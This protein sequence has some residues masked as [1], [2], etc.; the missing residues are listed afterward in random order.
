MN[1]V[2]KQFASLSKAGIVVLIMTVFLSA[3]RRDNKDTVIPVISCD[4]I[5]ND[6]VWA[7]RG[8]SID[9]IVNCVITVNAK[10]TIA[11]GVVIQFKNNAGIII[12]SAGT[13]VAAGTAAKPIVLKGDVDIAGVWKGLY[14]KS[15]NVL[16][17]LN[18]CTVTNAGSGSFDGSSAKVANIRLIIESK[19][20]LQNSTISKSGK[21]GLLVDGFDTDERNPLTLFAANTFSGNMNYPVSAIGAVANSL[22]GTGSSYTGNTYDKVQLRGGR[23][24]GSHTWTKLNVPYLV[25]AIVSAGYYNDNGSLT[26]QPGATIQFTG[27][28]GLCT[29]DY[30][31]TSWMSI[32]GTSAE[33]ITLTGE[34]AAPGAWKGIAFQSNS[35]NNRVSYTDISYGGGSSYTGSSTK[36]GNI[37]GGAWSAGTFTIDNAAINHSAGYGIYISLGSPSVSVPGSVTYSGNASGN[38]YHE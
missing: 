9:Y 1:K 32:A 12:E 27:N 14:I 35:P 25:T 29:G 19:L 3:C 36:L 37:V 20:K 5:N 15:N 22:D 24:Y 16:N 23:L 17:E 28:G 4:D 31:T 6:V 13:L 10:L 34:T 18:Y 38:Y 26:I 7:D 8:D 33:R 30:S 21:D 11:P 2:I